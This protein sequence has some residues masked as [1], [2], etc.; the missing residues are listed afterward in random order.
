MKQ[1]KSLKMNEKKPDF[2]CNGLTILDETHIEWY[3]CNSVIKIG[4]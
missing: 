4:L 2:F 3:Q 1:N